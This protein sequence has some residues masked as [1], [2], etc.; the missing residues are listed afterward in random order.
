VRRLRARDVAVPRHVVAPRRH[1]DPGRARP[2]VARPAALGAAPEGTLMMR[3][4]PAAPAADPLLG[5]AP[6]D[7]PAAAD[8]FAAELDA[9]TPVAEEAAAPATTPPAPTPEPS[10]TATPILLPAPG[11]TAPPAAP[12]DDVEPPAPAPPAP[13]ADAA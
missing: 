3:I 7:D 11:E 2:R 1:P 9:A 10:A 4:A 6:S 13:V 5:S 8:A 12:A